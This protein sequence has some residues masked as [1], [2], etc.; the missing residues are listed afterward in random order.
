MDYV[1][2]VRR[3]LD[4]ANCFLNFVFC[5]LLCALRGREIRLR[6]TQMGLG[7]GK[8]VATVLPRPYGFSSPKWSKEAHGRQRR[9]GETQVETREAIC[10]CQL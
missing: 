3:I 9:N 7:R 1:G 5:L 6:S 10:S 8:F 4:L 2:M